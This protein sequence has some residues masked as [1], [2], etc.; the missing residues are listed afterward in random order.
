MDTKNLT[1]SCPCDPHHDS[2]WSMARLC[3]APVCTFNLHP[4][5]PEAYRVSGALAYSRIGVSHHRHAARS[6]VAT[7]GSLVPCTRAV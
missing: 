4:P 7:D 5:L 1:V 2:C 6:Q 3:L